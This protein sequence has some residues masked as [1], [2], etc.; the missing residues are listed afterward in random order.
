MRRRRRRIQHTSYELR[1]GE[2]DGLELEEER[3]DVDGGIERGEV[4]GEGTD[5]GEGGEEVGDVAGLGG[6]DGGVDDHEGDVAAE[7]R[8][9]GGEAGEGD[10]VAH[11]GAR[12][13]DDVRRSVAAGGRHFLST[14]RRSHRFNFDFYSE[15]NTPLISN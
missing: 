15:P 9:R 5:G 4:E 1:R 8:E 10:Q 2:T 13:E 6:G 3:I 14:S 12:Q 11:A 7:G